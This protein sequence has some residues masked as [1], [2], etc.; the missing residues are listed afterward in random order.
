MLVNLQVFMHLSCVA[1]RHSNY[2][3]NH[4]MKNNTYYTA[5]KTALASA[6]AQG[7]SIWGSYLD[8]LGSYDY[9][10]LTVMWQ[11]YG[12]GSDSI[13]GFAEKIR[14]GK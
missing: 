4:D 12:I 10:V 13:L 6:F 3:P 9:A 11:D 8:N 2:Q 1:A 7:S 14:K 5:L